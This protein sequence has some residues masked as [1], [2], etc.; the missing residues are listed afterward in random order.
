MG[1]WVVGDFRR[2]VREGSVERG[3]FKVRRDVPI[4]AI[5]LALLGFSVVLVFQ[6]AATEVL[7][8]ASTVYPGSRFETGGGGAALL[9]NYGE[10]LFFSVDPARALPNACEASKVFSLFPAGIVIAIL[11]LVKLRK[12]DFL[13]ISLLVLDAVFLV[14][15]CVGVPAIVAKVT[16]LSNVPVG[17]MVIATGY[18]D[19]VLLLRGLVVYGE[20]RTSEVQA[21]GTIAE[22]RVPSRL[23]TLAASVVMSAVMVLAMRQLSGYLRLLYCVML[24]AI[25]TGL[26]YVIV[27]L[28]AT[29][30]ADPLYHKALLAL[31]AMTLVPSGLTVNPIQV[32]APF[33]SE[34]SLMRTIR[35]VNESEGSSDTLWLAVD[36]NIIVPNLCAAAGA[37]TLNCT[38]SIPNLDAWHSVDPTGAYESVYNRYAHILVRLTDEATSFD[39]TQPDHF[40]VDLT[41][42][43]L[44]TLGITNLISTEPLEGSVDDGV[45]LDKKA[46]VDGYYLY[47]VTYE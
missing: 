7:E 12:R 6:Y 17:R 21:E 15:M 37:P 10:G 4:L 28:V 44:R 38:N 13:L 8:V 2:E 9:L 46:E 14:F 20:G 24:F 25:M 35:S 45:H 31:L 33:Y 42:G 19:V 40:E 30:G 36:S 1:L 27:R 32:G 47:G 11:A 22:R 34:S 29:R 18:L 41:Y 23:L 43:D 16:L 39:L 3:T 26:V 5:P